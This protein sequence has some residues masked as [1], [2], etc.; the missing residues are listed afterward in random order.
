MGKKNLLKPLV[1]ATILII[2][3]A[4]A[5]FSLNDGTADASGA[6]SV[7]GVENADW[8]GR[9]AA[10]GNGDDGP[11]GIAV[12]GG[13][14]VY[15]TGFSEGGSSG[16]DYATVKYDANGNEKWVSRYIG[17]ILPE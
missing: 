4:T 12:D 5:V 10:A 6:I 1:L 16:W 17:V 8:E 13:G 2:L 9:Y 15:V 14:N 7:P 11:T 3:P